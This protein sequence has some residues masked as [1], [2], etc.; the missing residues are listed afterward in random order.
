MK[1]A[2]LLSAFAAL[3]LSATAQNIRVDSQESGAQITNGTTITYWIPTLNGSNPWVDVRHFTVTN[4][5]TSAVTLKVRKNNIVLADVA[6]QTTFCT[7]LNCYGP[8]QMLSYDVPMNA[9]ASFDLSLDYNTG[10][11]TGITRVMYT[12][13]NKNNVNDSTNLILEYNVVNGPASVINPTLIKPSVTNPM[14]NPATSMFAMTYKFGST[15]PG[16]AK[17]VVYNMLGAAVLENEILSAE[18]T[19]RM[20]VSTLPAGVYFCTLTNNGRQLA[21]KR[22]VVSH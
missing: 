4:T 19:I 10:T 12:I 14:P 18:G 8:G 1:K 21:T 16:D 11:M 13:Y 3:T 6:A 5:T 22:L 2:L 9:G 17:L 15:V 7:D 20:D